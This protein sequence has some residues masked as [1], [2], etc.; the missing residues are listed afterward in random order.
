[1]PECS[2]GFAMEALPLEVSADE[3]AEEGRPGKAIS[4]EDNFDFDFS[5]TFCRCHLLPLQVELPLLKHPH[6]ECHQ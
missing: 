3:M 5:E 6:P 1:M 2:N 4:L